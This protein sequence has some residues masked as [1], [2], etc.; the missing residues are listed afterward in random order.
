M[1]ALQ[2]YWCLNASC[3][4]GYCLLFCFPSGYEF[5][6]SEEFLLPCYKL[7][8]LPECRR[9]GRPCPREGTGGQADAGGVTHVPAPACPPRYLFHGA[10]DGLRSASGPWQGVST[11]LGRNPFH[12]HLCWI[13]EK[14]TELFRTFLRRMAQDEGQREGDG[15][16]QWRGQPFFRPLRISQPC[17]AASRIGGRAVVSVWSAQSPHAPSP[18]PSDASWPPAGPTSGRA[19]RR[20]GP[21]TSHADC[22]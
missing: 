19:A 8:A 15:R 2:D 10:E 17:P 14:H 18:S 16:A 5:I 11:I 13:L 20:Q 9:D 4:I 22:R 3:N 21:A 7:C 6:S 12:E 1:C